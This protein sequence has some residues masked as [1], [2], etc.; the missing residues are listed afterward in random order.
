M[1]DIPSRDWN[2]FLWAGSKLRT[3]AKP[4][5]K[6]EENE[7]SQGLRSQQSTET[8]STASRAGGV[9]DVH[10]QGTL[11]APSQKGAGHKAWLGPVIP[12]KPKSLEGVPSV[13]R[14]KSG[15]E[16]NPEYR[17]VKKK[18]QHFEEAV[19]AA[20]G[21]PHRVEFTGGM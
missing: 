11:N 20:K 9:L 7:E 6:N 15:L 21:N 2:P 13:R 5:K 4:K 1:V 3:P 8:Q 10:F 12:P 16:A 17:E 14:G 19:G 18:I